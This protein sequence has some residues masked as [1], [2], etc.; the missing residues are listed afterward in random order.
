MSS[1]QAIES[2]NM[3]VNFDLY[4][5]EENVLTKGMHFVV[6][7]KCLDSHHLSVRYN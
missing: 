5:K 2:E 3:Y 1:Y 6:F 4:N 7:R